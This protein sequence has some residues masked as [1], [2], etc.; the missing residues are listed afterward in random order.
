MKKR[1][2]IQKEQIF[3][4]RPEYSETDYTKADKT[5]QKINKT[6]LIVDKQ[7]QQIQG[8]ISQIGDRSEKT[9]T[10]TADIEGLQSQVSDIESLTEHVN[11]RTKIV[12]ENCLKGEIVKL[13]IKGNSL[14]IKGLYPSKTLYPKPKGVFAQLLP[15]DD[16]LPDDNLLPYGGESQI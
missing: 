10:I 8:I 4:E 13:I 6:S 5:D 2:I 15:S 14:E 11:G 9:T 3:T 7:G 12:L 16:L 1:D